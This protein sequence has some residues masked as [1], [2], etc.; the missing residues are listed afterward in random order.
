MAHGVV[1]NEG[2][3][4]D[5]GH[6]RSLGIF[7]L[8]AISFFT[9]SGGMHLVVVLCALCWFCKGPYG[10]EAIVSTAPI[11]I[12]LLSFIVIPILW[13]TPLS[14]ITAGMH[15]THHPALSFTL[16]L[17]LITLSILSCRFLLTL[18]TELS[19]MIPQDGGSVL[20]VKEVHIQH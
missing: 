16:I 20:W 14:L 15:S 5:K 3:S 8:I 10:I 2:G 19:T 11:L 6:V 1:I 12:V 13:S 4:P 18:S 9:V 7:Q 17:I